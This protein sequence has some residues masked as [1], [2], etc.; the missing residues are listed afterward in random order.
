[1]FKKE[2]SQQP[3]YSKGHDLL[4]KYAFYVLIFFCIFIPFRSPIADLTFSGI[5]AITDLLTLSVL[6]WFAVDSRLHLRFRLQDFLFLGFL[7][8]SFI[9][10]VLVNDRSIGVFIYQVRSIGIY[11]IFY[12][13]IRNFG[14]GKKEFLSI[15]RVL[16]WVS[17]ALMSLGIIEKI[18]AKTFLFPDSVANAILYPSNFTRVYSMFYNP[19]TFGLFIIMTILL[20]WTAHLFL[21]HRT[22][23]AIYCV[24]FLSLWLSMSRSS[25]IMVV[26]IALVFLAY[27]LLTRQFGQKWLTILKTSAAVVLVVVC[28]STLVDLGSQYYYDKYI[29]THLVD[30]PPAAGDSLDVDF[31]DR[32]DEVNSDTIVDNSSSD[33]RLFSVVTSLK[34]MRDYPLVGAGFGSYGSAASLAYG[35]HI[36]ED[37]KL[38]PSFYSDI[39]YAKLVAEN[40]ILG[41]LLF[42]AFLLTILYENRTSFFKVALCF[43]IMWFGLFYNIFEVQIGSMLLWSFLSMDVDHTFKCLGKAKANIDTDSTMD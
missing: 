1:M 13:C 36:A 29:V 33:G 22:N 32:L 30:S 2:L 18:T 43:T 17:V 19:N 34:V 9:S 42:I 7:G 11:Y 15:L 28:A 3:V 23:I 27:I 31:L 14:Y 6:A 12:F 26:L 20:S 37:Y 40:G 24:L 16:Q 5:K 35:S 4:R 21:G 38:S 41:T 25:L 39:E 8:L 10:T